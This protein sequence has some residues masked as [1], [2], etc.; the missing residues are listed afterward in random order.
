M[1]CFL[2]VPDEINT[3]AFGKRL[4]CLHGNPWR[5][6]SP[7]RRCRSSRCCIYRKI[8]Y[9]CEY[10][11]AV[12]KWRR[13]RLSPQGMHVRNWAILRALS[14]RLNATLPWNSLQEL[15][16]AMYAIA[17]QLAKL[18]SIEV[19]D[20]PALS[21]LSKG[22]GSTTREPFCSPCQGFLPYQ[23]HCARLAYHG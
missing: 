11:R 19:A 22:E 18:D 2:P 20:G 10:R 3:E 13:A 6:R 1:S 14:E 15:R 8:G 12:L 23:P 21:E 7:S 16:S 4:C 5:R 9:I 17:P